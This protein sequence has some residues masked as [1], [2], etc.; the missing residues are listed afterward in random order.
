[1]SEDKSAEDDLGCRNRQI[2]FTI[3]LWLDFSVRCGAKMLW[4]R[5]KDWPECSSDGQFHFR[6]TRFV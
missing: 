6:D 1:M 3:A 4:R 5:M 2:F